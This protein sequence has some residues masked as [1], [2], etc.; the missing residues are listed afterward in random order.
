[1]AR[2]TLA[3]SPSYIMRKVVGEPA[4]PL[5]IAYLGQALQEEHDVVSLNSGV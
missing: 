4:P 1:M 3:F 5:G 2:I